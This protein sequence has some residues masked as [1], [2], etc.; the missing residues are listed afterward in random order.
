MHYN[1]EPVKTPVVFYYRRVLVLIKRA[2]TE[3]RN[4][5]TLWAEAEAK[6]APLWTENAALRKQ[7]EY[8]R[9]GMDAAQRRAEEAEQRLRDAIARLMEPS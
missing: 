2:R 1:N 8:Y 7:M 6:N 9:T 5:H 3:A 4:W